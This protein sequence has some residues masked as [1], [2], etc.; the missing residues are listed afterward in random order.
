MC[1]LMQIESYSH[2]EFEIFEY[3]DDDH[4]ETKYYYYKIYTN[5]S[6]YKFWRGTRELAESCEAYDT[7]LESVE[8]AKAHI[9]RIENGEP[10]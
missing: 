2:Y 8:E 9:D 7:E 10:S 1:T 6:D 4:P 5:D 3:P